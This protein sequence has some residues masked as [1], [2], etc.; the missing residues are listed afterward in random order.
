[1]HTS[2]SAAKALCSAQQDQILFRQ[3][4]RLLP[5]VT[6]SD[7]P[8]L[9]VL[10]QAIQLGDAAAYRQAIVDLRISSV[11]IRRYRNFVHPRAQLRMVDPPDTDTL[12]ICWRI[13]NATLNDLAGG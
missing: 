1:M 2:I 7:P 3:L 9:T 5:A 13:V 8:E 10:R 4:T 11:L 12:D 6:D